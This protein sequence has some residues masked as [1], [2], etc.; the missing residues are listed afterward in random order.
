MLLLLYSPFTTSIEEREK[1]YSIILSRTPH[2]TKFNRIEK[3]ISIGG[4][5]RKP[6]TNAMVEKEHPMSEPIEHSDNIPS[7]DISRAGWAAPN[8][9]RPQT[10]TVAE[11]MFIYD[12]LH[13]GSLRPRL[14]W[15]VTAS[16]SDYYNLTS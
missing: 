3:K 5:F 10:T 14:N 15:C 2:E 6:A 8:Q 1:C 4:N 9:D 7:K 16:Y 13:L 11:R 12:R